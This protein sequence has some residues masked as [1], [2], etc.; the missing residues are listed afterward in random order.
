M[1]TS[2][3]A[4]LARYLFMNNVEEII[5]KT[6]SEADQSNLLD[7]PSNQV[8]QDGVV[9]SSKINGTVACFGRP[10]SPAC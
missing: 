3:T 7:F 2:S 8:D 5:Q 1:T 10:C 4:Y 6:L 9:P